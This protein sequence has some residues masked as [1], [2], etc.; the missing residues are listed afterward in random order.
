MQFF[1]LV[2]DSA[3]DSYSRLPSKKVAAHCRVSLVCAEYRNSRTSNPLLPICKTS[4]HK[5]LPLDGDASGN[6]STVVDSY[7]GT[8]YQRRSRVRAQAETSDGS[9]GTS[10][11]TTRRETES[12]LT[13]FVSH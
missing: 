8:H 4:L 2:V 5:G 1:W 11:A 13:E 7:W 6:N 9:P 3:Q 12:T 10:E